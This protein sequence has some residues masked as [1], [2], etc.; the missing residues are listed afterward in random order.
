M[1]TVILIFLSL[2]ATQV[3]AQ[4]KTTY[5]AG[6]GAT[7]GISKLDAGIGYYINAGLT[8]KLSDR[9]GVIGEAIYSAEQAGKVKTGTASGRLM[10]RVYPIGKLSL[11]AGF[12]IGLLITNN[13]EEETGTKPSKG[14][15]SGVF[16]LAYEFN[17]I[18]VRAIYNRHL[19]EI[20]INGS[21]QVGIGYKF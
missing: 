13:L 12:Q 2:I 6:A 15:M 21:L 3:V 10:F 19:E 4:E 16:G 18:E 8:N 11:N 20:P 17:K 9:L 7:Y 1:K 14:N 5:H